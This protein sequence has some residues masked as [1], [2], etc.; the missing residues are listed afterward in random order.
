MSVIIWSLVLI[1]FLK[2][3]CCEQIILLCSKNLSSLL[4]KIL[5]KKNPRQLDIAIPLSQDG[6]FAQPPLNKGLIKFSL[7]IQ[8]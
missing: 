4:N 3:I 5:E 8:M 7:Q 2:P 1:A 6:S